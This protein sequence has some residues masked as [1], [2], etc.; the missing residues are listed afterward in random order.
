MTQETRDAVNNLTTAQGAAR[1]GKIVEPPTYHGRDDEDPH[2]WITMFDQAFTTNG[3][4]EGNNQTRKIAIAAGYLRDSAQDWYQQDKVNIQRFHDNAHN[5]GANNLTTRLLEHFSSQAKRNMWM[6]ELQNIKQKDGE[7]VEEYARRFRKV[8]KRVTHTDALANVYQVNYFINGL[9]PALIGQ[10][11]LGNHANLDEA[12]TRAKAVEM[13]LQFTLQSMT[14]TGNVLNN[15]NVPNNF[16]V[17]NQQN[18]V[19]DQMD[20]LTRRFEKMQINLLNQINKAKASGETCYNCGKTG[21]RANTCKSV[22]CFKCGGEGHTSKYC[23]EGCKTCGQ[24]NHTTEKCYRNRKCERCGQRGHTEKFCRND[25]R[26][27]NYA[28]YDYGSESEDDY[29]YDEYYE[30]S[31]EELFVTTRGGKTTHRMPP[32]SESKK[33][34]KFGRRKKSEDDMDID[35]ERIRAKRFREKSRIEKGK[36][37]NVVEDLE[38]TR[39]SATIAQMLQNPEQRKM[40][41]QAL[42]GEFFQ[43]LE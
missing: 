5:G 26:R 9:L 25:V 39:S 14:M 38:N 6:R 40:L 2:E 11:M 32:R 10:T 15:T 37:Y 22:K 7:S 3:W 16:N 20:E 21:H 34:V 43:E 19:E 36:P 29:Y 4:Q 1:T 41:R 35:D 33:E 17:V 13:S 31:D 18:K 30:D 12:I 24:N 8:L 23:K 27:V 28:T 42:K